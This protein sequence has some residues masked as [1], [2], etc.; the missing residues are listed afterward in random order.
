MRGKNKIPIHELVA[1]KAIPQLRFAP[2][3]F[4]CNLIHSLYEHRTS[5]GIIRVGSRGAA[6]PYMFHGVESEEEFCLA[7]LFIT[8]KDNV[9]HGIYTRA[10]KAGSFVYTHSMVERVARWWA[11]PDDVKFRGYNIG[12]V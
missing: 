4:D 5:D 9:K 10:A 12:R 2:P 11:L 8:V 1:D 7:L 3:L 6:F